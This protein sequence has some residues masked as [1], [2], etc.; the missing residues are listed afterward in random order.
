MQKETRGCAVTDSLPVNS[1]AE[2][3]ENG[4]QVI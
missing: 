2:M 1:R 4:G 3:A